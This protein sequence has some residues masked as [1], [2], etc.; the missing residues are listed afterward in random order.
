MEIVEKLMRIV[1]VVI[2]MRV[3]MVMMAV[4]ITKCRG[5]NTCQALY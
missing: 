2:F 5:L 4:M 1:M 3:I